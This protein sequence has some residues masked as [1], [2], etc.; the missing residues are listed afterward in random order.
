MEGLRENGGE[1]LEN[2]GMA[3]QE[4]FLYIW[5][6][7]KP[8]TPPRCTA[9]AAITATVHSLLTATTLLYQTVTTK[10]TW[11][12]TPRIIRSNLPRMLQSGDRGE[13]GRQE[14]MKDKSGVPDREL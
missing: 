5:L 6:A 13:K 2:G 12:C 7:C 14:A 11:S 3:A 8:L 4:W 9:A 1:G 10:R